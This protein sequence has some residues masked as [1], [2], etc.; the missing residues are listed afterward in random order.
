M[1]AKTPQLSAQRFLDWRAALARLHAQVRPALHPGAPSAASV[2]LNRK[3]VA[4][5]DVRV[6][7]REG[8]DWIEYEIV[9][10][11]HGGDQARAR[12]VL[13][14]GR[15]GEVLRAFVED[16]TSGAPSRVAG[17]LALQGDAELLCDVELLDDP[18]ARASAFAWVVARGTLP[19][20]RPMR[21]GR[22]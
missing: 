22:P 15:T 5:L 1:D 7:E 18:E 20:A 13:Y 6:V 19:P 17:G 12:V 14:D 21:P 3:V 10:Y 4:A 11:L 8:A 16:M 9:L 2:T